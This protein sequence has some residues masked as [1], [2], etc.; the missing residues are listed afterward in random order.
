[1][2]PRIDSRVEIAAASCLML[3][4]TLAFFAPLLRGATFSTVAG[5]QAAVYPW[6]ALQPQYHDFPQSDQ[7]DLNY[8]WR[9]F[10]TR[11]LGEGVLPFWNPYSFGGQPFLANGSSAVLYPPHLA[12][13]LLVSPDWAHDLFSLLHVALA[14][15]STYLLMREFG[16]GLPGRLLAAVAWMFASFNMAWLH[17]EVVAPTALWLPLD[18]LLVS[19]AMRGESWPAAIGTVVAL[20]CTLV[21]GHLLF[22]G[23]VYG[24]SIAYA[25]ALLLARLRHRFGEDDPPHRAEVGRHLL[26]TALVVVGPLCLAAI[27]LV[28]TALYLHGLGRESLPYEAART[29]IHV[30]Y[31]VFR[32]LLAPPP[33]PV[34]QFTMHEMVFVGTIPALLAT[35][36]IFRRQVGT[37]L[38]RTL[39]AAVFL[40]ATDTVFLR[41]VYSV[42]PQFSFFSPL[43]RLLNLFAFGVVILA[44][45]GLDTV[46]R[47]I[48][49]RPAGAALAG[50]SLV[51][52]TWQLLSY[53]RDINPPFPPRSA[54]SLYPETPLISAL[55]RAGSA[56]GTAPGRIFPVRRSTKHGWKAPILFATE[57]LMFGI[58]S[59]AGYDSTLP[60]RAETIWRIVSGEPAASVLTMGYRRAF[61]SSFEIDAVRFELLPRLGITTIVGPPQLRRDPLWTPALYAPLSLTELYQGM[62]GVAYRIEGTSG[63]PWLVYRAT[64]GDGARQVLTRFLASSFDAADEVVFDRHDLPPGSDPGSGERGHGR[65]SVV[66]D[67]INSLKVQVTTDRPGW[68]VV[69]N[70]WEAGWRAVVDGRESPVVRANYTS[71]AVRVEPRTSLVELRYRPGGWVFGASLSAVT[72]VA[73]VAVHPRLP[74]DPRASATS[75][76]ADRRNHPGRER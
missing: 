35:A 12:S 45:I 71:Q 32:Y 21:S 42:F 7:A 8:P 75:R 23:L 20:A 76:K 59:A 1:L 39:V 2:P 56:N 24:L 54:W 55:G 73:L 6:R 33:L 25:A 19:R 13:A 14:G 29:S 46:L 53:A 65:V 69:P 9:T 16:T 66:E 68:L 10:V 11:A 3:A 27:V 28:P 51:I 58:D 38:A 34:T 52:T 5:H 64:V 26:R 40:V 44:G 49:W 72:L 63:G 48:R 47:W 62:D 18:V 60:E 57:S 37:G 61:Q 70:T 67:G 36:G 30:P 41:V 50:A 43:G 15:L 17:V 4:L 74:P 31:R 22:A